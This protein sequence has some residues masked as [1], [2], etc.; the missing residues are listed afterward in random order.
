[1]SIQDCSIIKLPKIVDSRGNLSFI[2]GG[3]HIPFAI[4]RIYYLYDIP[5]AGTRGEHAHKELCQ[6]II[7]ISG[8]FDILID[9]GSNR[10]TL[11]LN[12]P[13]EGLFITNMIW[14]EITNFSKDAVCMVLASEYYD[15]NDYF[16]TYED[17]LKAA[18]G[19]ED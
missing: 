12:E 16:R 7:A 2:E 1:M 6:L 13:N 19:E 10:K 8:S 9:D 11:T 17:F 4:K 5:S 15:E 3:R 18:K 14:R